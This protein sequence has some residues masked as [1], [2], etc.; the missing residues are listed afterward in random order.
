MPKQ[1][2]TGMAFKGSLILFV[3][4]LIF[5]KVQFWGYKPAAILPQK[6]FDVRLHL[7]V[8]DVAG[9][10]ELTM[11]LPASDERQ[12]IKKPV[13]L[14]S[15]PFTIDHDDHG[16]LGHWQIDA[17]HDP[18]SI[19]YAFHV[20][21]LETIYEIPDDLEIPLSYPAAVATYRNEAVADTLKPLPEKEG[22]LLLP[23]TESL[24]QQARAGNCVIAS[25]TS[26]NL[27][28]VLMAREANIPARTAGG[29]LL[30]LR[31]NS[32]QQQWS[33]LY[34]NGT[35]VPFDVS[36]GH[37]ASLPANY[38]KL[39]HGDV[40]MLSAPGG[41][42]KNPR[43]EVREA[44]VSEAFLSDAAAVTAAPLNPFRLWRSFLDVGMP[45]N[46]LK[47]LLL[48]PIGAMLV[49]FFR[50]VIGLE[51]YGV[52]LPALIATSGL[53]LGLMNTVGGFL[54]V[55]LLVALIHF[56]L[57]KSGLLYVPKLALMLLAVVGILIGLT[58]V[59]VRFQLSDF[60]SF[61]LLPLVILAISAER[62]SQHLGEEGWQKA[63]R[64]LGMTLIVIAACYA[65][66]AQPGV[67]WL[68]IAFP[69]L[70]LIVCVFNMWMGRWIGIRLTEYSRFKWLI[71]R[72]GGK[73]ALQRFHQQ[74]LP[75]N[76]RNG[77][78][79]HEA[80][81]KAD[82]IL[83]NDKVITKEVLQ[84]H[85]IAVPPT[86]MLFS[87][88][89]SLRK[90]WGRLEK[91]DE[92]VIKPANGKRGNSILVLSR[93]DKGWV[94]PGGRFYDAAALKK[95]IAD[96]I[97][98]T[99]SG[100]TWD[101]A[102][103]EYRVYAHPFF[104]RIYPQGLPDIRIITHNGQIVQ[105]MLRLPT[106]DSDGKANLHQGA[107]GVGIDLNTGRL[108]QGYDYTQYLEVHPDSGIPLL[109][110]RVPFWEEILQICRQIASIIPL[111]YLGIDIV[112]DKDRGPMVLE[113]NARPGIEIQNVNRQGL[114]PL[115]KQ[116]AHAA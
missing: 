97:F 4:T 61:S 50:N 46:S 103:L 36:K 78:I 110:L 98:G 74:V 64:V 33:E 60:M 13:Y 69:E 82:F 20:R 96:I 53:E 44:L 9:D 85:Q 77:K 54:L 7:F 90:D 56:P 93:K 81:R 32:S 8:E 48:I 94:T 6:G 28:F 55:T 65:I 17:S 84:Q 51:T 104:Q 41:L 16:R 52:F 86:L 88:V 15:S 72:E 111:Q 39:Y 71:D 91:L 107:L 92:F 29:L 106:K 26:G 14:G 19:S 57:E 63:L 108:K 45:L 34:I 21:A 24:F 1:F 79:I 115:L 95:H 10:E 58:F 3:V 99:H 43:I 102:I 23:V 25:V 30:D 87:E 62:F 49:A 40:N 31:S 75:I 22:Q 27:C 35:W 73:R 113:I 100:G 116:N 105:G 59:G 114:R 67:Q 70:L 2:P 83:A 38:L 37:F 5:V 11:Y 47:I 80:N 109:H 42:L 66:I 76:Y 12:E 18:V 112:I 89:G 101:T 68:F